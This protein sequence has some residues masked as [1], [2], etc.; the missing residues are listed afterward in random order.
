MNRHRKK[1]FKPQPAS[2][3]LV[4]VLAT[5]D[6]GLLAV[7]KSVLDGAGIK[8]FVRNELLQNILP[9]QSGAFGAVVEIQVRSGDAG[10]VRA[11]LDV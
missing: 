11:L 8:Y 1:S 4:T 10:E 7:V 9:V 6:A 5:T 3:D 2:S